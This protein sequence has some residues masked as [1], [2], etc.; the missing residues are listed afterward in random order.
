S[1]FRIGS[2]ANRRP[3]STWSTVTANS[4]RTFFGSRTAASWWTTS[5]SSTS[6]AQHCRPR[7]F[8]AEMIN[9]FQPSAGDAELA[10]I[11][12]VFSS[13]WLGTGDRVAQFERA[14]GEYI[15]RPPAEVLAVSS[16]T[17]GLFH[18]IAALRLGRG[19]DV[20]LQTIS[21]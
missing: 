13:N 20:I 1:S 5:S 18:A 7:S 14:F 15:G 12:E 10:A 8:G 9:L 19:D 21:V 17:E 3:S 2:S 11:K 4:R 16:C 6:R